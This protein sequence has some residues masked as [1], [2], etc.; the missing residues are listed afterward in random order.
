MD[1]IQVRIAAALQEVAQDH[2]LGGGAVEQGGDR[3]RIAQDARGQEQ[4][5]DAESLHRLPRGMD[6][7]PARADQAHHPHQP[8]AVGEQVGDPGP[9][10]RLVLSAGGVFQGERRGLGDP[11]AVPARHPG[12]AGDRD[13]G[14]AQGPG[15]RG[16]AG[17]DPGPLHVR[18][19]V[20]QG[21]TGRVRTRV[22]APGRGAI[23]RVAVREFITVAVAQLIGA[24]GAL[25]RVRLSIAHPRS[26]RLGFRRR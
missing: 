23:D 12:E 25:F 10:V 26:L 19:A 14:C 6:L 20:E 3:D 4:F 22:V 7:D 21:R 24:E 2:I 16:I 9:Q 18:V 11:A 15:V 17:I 1:S 5:P 8:G 13:I